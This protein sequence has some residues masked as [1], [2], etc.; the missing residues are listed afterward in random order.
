MAESENCLIFAPY[1]WSTCAWNARTR[2]NAGFFRPRRIAMRLPLGIG[3]R[4]DARLG[5][6][7]GVGSDGYSIILLTHPRASWNRLSRPRRVFHQSLGGL[8]AIER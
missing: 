6:S 3:Y 1:Q 5:T 7:L 8:A 4:S 2:R